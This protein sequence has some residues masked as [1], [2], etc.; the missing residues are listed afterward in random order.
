MSGTTVVQ[1]PRDLQVRFP[2]RCIE[3]GLPEC[4]SGVPV[5][6]FGN[7]WR[8]FFFWWW[9]GKRYKVE[10]PACELCGP[11]IRRARTLRDWMRYV[12]PISASLLWIRIAS[13]LGLPSN[14]FAIFGVFLLVL[15]IMEWQFTRRPHCVD[16]DIANERVSF[17]FRDTAF[18]RD[19]VHLNQEPETD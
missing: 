4:H 19:F 13:A 10:I 8:R 7:K 6:G 12:V 9:L 16:I 3:C 15:I 11:R 5:W 1:V 2:D 17:E 18:A 14:M